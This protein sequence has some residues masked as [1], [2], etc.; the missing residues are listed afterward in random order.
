MFN[1]NKNSYFRENFNKRPNTPDF[2]RNNRQ[3]IPPVTISDHQSANEVNFGN[4][5]L[6][7]SYVPNNKELQNQNPE[8]LL[9]QNITSKPLAEIIDQKD[10]II[11]SS[12]RNT[13][14]KPNIFD[15]TVNFGS[16]NQPSIIRTLKNVKYIKLSKAYFPENYKIKR[17]TIFNTSSNIKQVNTNSSTTKY[18]VMGTA[19]TS[20]D[21]S[22]ITSLIL[23][24]PSSGQINV[25]AGGGSVLN[26]T[27][28]PV[29][30]VV[31]I[32]LSSGSSDFEGYYI[33]KTA[34]TDTVV[35]LHAPSSTFDGSVASV[36]TNVN[37]T[38]Y[39]FATRSKVAEDILTFTRGTESGESSNAARF[40][41]ATLLDND[42]STMAGIT[43]LTKNVYIIWYGTVNNKFI[44]DF[45]YEDEGTSLKPDY[46]TVYSVI[47]N[48]TDIAT[49]IGT[50]SDNIDISKLEILYSY[51]LST[52]HSVK[53][54]RF[55]QL[56][57]DEIPAK[58]ELAT[59]SLIRNS[60][61]LLYPKED[62]FND[63]IELKGKDTD[64]IFPFS[65]LLNI[66][67]LTIKLYD[68]FGNLLNNDNDTETDDTALI[69]RNLSG[70]ENNNTIIS[71]TNSK[72]NEK[73]PNSFRSPDLYLRHNYYQKAQMQLIFT[74]GEVEVRQNM[75]P[76]A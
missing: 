23:S 62:N 40:A 44:L 72:N 70:T 41:G 59:T 37:V 6:S 24:N 67:S 60:Y 31:Q 22:G 36:T 64:K 56:H 9:D 3:S 43:G 66:N 18:Y 76:F 54:K 4:N 65:N 74:I 55:Y 68:N 35:V 32:S 38:A 39:R 75:N 29:G 30:R 15:F 19:S 33:V 12:D 16:N 21:D 49:K 48:T 1:N 20:I 8:V 50:F 5:H 10:L 34:G 57:I 11:D 25:T 7:L 42:S 27:N 52:Y 17:T 2:S 47:I 28:F 51:T 46:K 63:Y 26:S 13:T 71:N 45:F 73:Y 69:N 14:S 58:N 61:C 53:N